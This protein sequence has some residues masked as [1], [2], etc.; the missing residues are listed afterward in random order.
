MNEENLIGRV[1]ATEKNPTTTDDFTFWADDEVE[2]SPFDIVKA[3]NN[4]GEKSSITYAIIED[5]NRITDSPNHLSNYISSDFGNVESESMT[6]RVEVT[7]AT[8]NIINN[9][10]D[11]QMPLRHHE[12]VYFPDEKE[13]KEALGLDKIKNPIPAGIIRSTNGLTVPISLSKHYLIGK[14]GAHLN[15]SGISGLATKTSYSMFICQALQ[16]KCDDVAIIIM[17]VKGSDLLRVNKLNNNVDINQKKLWKKCGL[18]YKTFDNV[19]FFYPYRDNNELYNVNTSLEKEMIEEQVRDNIL[20]R[21]VYTYKE[22]R[23]DIDLLFSDIRDDNHTIES[24]INY[25]SENEE[26]SEDNIKDWNQ[27]MNKL[28]D[29]NT[30]KIS[31]RTNK[32]ITANSWKRFTRLISRY[33]NDEIFESSVGDAPGIEQCVLKN[34]ISKIKNKDVFVIDIAQLDKNLQYLVFGDVLKSVN[35]LKFDN[36]KLT[37]EERRESAKNIVIFVDELN[38][39]A[40][41]KTSKDSPILNQLLDI[42]ERGRSEGIILFSAEQFKSDIHDRVKGNCATHVYG[43]TNNTEIQ[44]GDYK[45]IPKVYKNM[46]TRLGKGEL[47]L[48]HSIYSTPLKI[49]FPYPS[50]VQ[51]S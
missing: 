42:T 44:K 4:I 6:K 37:E 32:E 21:Y 50:Y 1:S 39:Y 33:T 51:G 8:A 17:N 30:S 18:E 15:I 29:Y 25:I 20:N 40:D 23:N 24:I 36:M 47:I 13:I 34:E 5:I 46:M 10:K 27:L 35:Q 7:F 14:E 26:F 19:K 16:Q 43:R 48:Y 28:N 12:K 31:Q 11:I 41:S 22:H 49:I 38:K 2:I 9:T 45:Y 3:E